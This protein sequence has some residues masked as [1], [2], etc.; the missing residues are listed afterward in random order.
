[1]IKNFMKKRN[2][3]RWTLHTINKD[4]LRITFEL[5]QENGSYDDTYVI[6]GKNI[7]SLKRKIKKLLKD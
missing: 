4:R 3:R 7:K 6:D 2:I 1:M 5:F